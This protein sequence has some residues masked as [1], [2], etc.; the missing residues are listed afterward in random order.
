MLPFVNCEPYSR[1]FWLVTSLGSPD[2]FSLDWSDFIMKHLL[3]RLDC[4]QSE[5]QEEKERGRRGSRYSV[6]KWSVNHSF[7]SSYCPLW[8]PPLPGTSQSRKL[9]GVCLVSVVFCFFFFPFYSKA[10][11]EEWKREFAWLCNWGLNYFLKR[12]SSNPPIFSPT[13]NLISWG[14]W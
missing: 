11:P 4:Q 14:N 8:S 12:L 6:C 3:S 13:F 2:D 10:K 1:V 7:S 5:Y 9:H